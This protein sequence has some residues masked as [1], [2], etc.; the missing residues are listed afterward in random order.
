MTN[1]HPC[2]ALV[3]GKCRNGFPTD[4]SCAPWPDTAGKWWMRPPICMSETRTARLFPETGA[5]PKFPLSR[6]GSGE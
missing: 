1:R 4:A 2:S 3:D 5:P 6:E